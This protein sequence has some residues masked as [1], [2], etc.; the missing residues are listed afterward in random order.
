MMPKS[1]TIEH[2]RISQPVLYT[3]NKIENIEKRKT[4]PINMVQSNNF[5]KQTQIIN[6]TNNRIT[7]AVPSPQLKQNLVLNGH[8]IKDRT[9][10]QQKVSNN[11]K[12]IVRN[13][14][15][16]QKNS[17]Q[18]QVI[19]IQEKKPVKVEEV[20]HFSKSQPIA[21]GKKPVKVQ[22]QV[23]SSP[24]AQIQSQPIKTLERP[25]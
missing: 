19:N 4:M 15:V 25:K 13:L 12:N 14:V 9:N 8:E 23:V 6:E 7:K 24:Q 10:F 3:Q 2:K 1:K 17:N 18:N 20:G 22:Q 16:E 5:E 21:Q 11:Q